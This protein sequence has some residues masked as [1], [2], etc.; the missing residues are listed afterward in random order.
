MDLKTIT[1]VRRVNGNGDENFDW[2]E[3]DS[4]LAGG[5]WL[6]SEPQPHL[7]RLVDLHGFDWE[8]LVVSE[9]GLQISPTCT[10][11]EL[12]ALDA[13]PEWTAAPLIRQC[14]HAFLAS[15]KVWNT[16]TV[17]GNICMSLP[18]GPMISLTV[19]LEGIYTLRL[20]DGSERRV[21]AE[22][23]VTGNNQNILQPGDLL[24]SIELPNT[25]L[26]KQTSFR[27][28]ALTHLGRSTALLVGTLSP[29]DG[30]FMLTV[31]AST[32]RPIRLS[33]DEVPDTRSL[34][35]RLRKTIPDSMYH[36]DVHGA[37]EYR[38]H[39]TY[40]FAEEIRGELAGD[41]AA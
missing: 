25:A 12:E 15:F 30:T 8:P 23:F 10:I 27:R 16:A 1:E 28:M 7:R 35:E 11:A 32:V 4:W 20:Q 19:A 34:R 21:P 29:Q 17:G 39:L 26:Q 14:C 3:G 40:H 38:K 6:F 33:F 2:R 37:P 22:E 13:P 36:N 41:Q 31:S 24:R 9:Q 5:T 18:A